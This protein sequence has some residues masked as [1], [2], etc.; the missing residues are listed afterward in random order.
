MVSS[1]LHCGKRA[2]KKTFECPGLQSPPGIALIDRKVIEPRTRNWAHGTRNSEKTLDKV[3]PQTIRSAVD[4]L[5]RAA[6]KATIVL[7]G[8][9]ARGDARNDSDIDFLVIEPQ[10]VA[11][12]AETVRLRDALRPLRIPV[13]VV[14]TSRDAYDKWAGTPGTLYYEAS[15]EGKILHVG[16]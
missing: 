12:R 10:V 3:D 13:D 7:F 16:S 2:R 1:A 4:L 11:R 5:S 6:P 9:H 15:R 14:V 8:S